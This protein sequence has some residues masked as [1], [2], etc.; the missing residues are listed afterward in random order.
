MY[1]WE[2][3]N[4]SVLLQQIAVNYVRRGYFF[5][6]QGT[7]PFSKDP[8]KTDEKIVNQYGIDV[9][10]W[11]NWRRRKNGDA[12]VHYVRHCRVFFILATAGEHRFFRDEQN[13]I[14]D[15]RRVPMKVAGYSIAYRKTSLG[16][17]VSVRLE[18]KHFKAVK[19]LFDTAARG[20]P[21]EN[22][23]ARLN[24]FNFEFYAPVCQQVS[25]IIRSIN[26]IRAKAGLEL[27]NPHHIF[28]SRKSQKIFKET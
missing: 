4:L 18:Q 7:I 9:S 16:D 23:E 28:H 24:G 1:S 25:R 27:V 14:R 13:A 21:V 20:E 6:V 19:E 8:K 22:L 17:R 10:K 11:T 2:V 3:R 26:R 15:V 12:S 5:Y